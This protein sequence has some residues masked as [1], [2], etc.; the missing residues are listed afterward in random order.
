MSTPAYA[1]SNLHIH[2]VTY[3]KKH[4]APRLDCP[5][6]RSFDCSFLQPPS[7]GLC[8]RYTGL[9]RPLSDAFFSHPANEEQYSANLRTCAEGIEG[10]R[11]IGSHVA[12]LVL[13]RAGMHRS[14]AMA[15]RLAKQISTWQYLD[16]TVCHF[17][18]RSSMLRWEQMGR[19]RYDWAGYD[20]FRV[21]GRLPMSHHH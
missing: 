12:I 11:L 4:E 9:D 8:S 20:S 3:A 21:R 7:N 18:L 13:C 5:I 10:W 1:K 6:V 14:V 16:A 17:D 2:F 19:G 15:E